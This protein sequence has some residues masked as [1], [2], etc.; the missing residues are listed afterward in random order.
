[1]PVEPSG[2]IV[3]GAPGPSGVRSVPG[4]LPSAFTRR[5]FLVGAAAAALAGCADFRIPGQASTVKSGFAE[6]PGT[7]LYYEMAGTGDE[8]VVL[9][10]AFM[11]DTR[12]WDEQFEAYAQRYRV[13][14]YDARG[15]GRS[16]VPH[17]GEPYSHADD[18]AALLDLLGATGPVHVVGLSMG[19]RFAL[20]FAVVHPARLRSLTVID[21]VVGGWPWSRQWL[22]SYA[23][24]LEAA[25]RGDIPGAKQA[26]LANEIFAPLREQPAV[27]GRMRQMVDDYSGW[28]L[29]NADPERTPQPPTVSQLSK[30]AAPTLVLVGERDV[31]EFQ[32]IAAQVARGVPGARHEKV[33][34]VGH[35]A[36]MEG[37]QRV[38]ELVVGFIAGVSG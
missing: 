9:I 6:I 31:P 32:M 29:V 3:L 38:N 22:V 12:T 13:I 11:L 16:G 28:H 23:P 21:T 27:A 34:G 4:V 37:P 7:R 18:L 5:R 1:M 10:H 36:S 25:R 2:T 30:V 14:R 26:W 24:V 35:L 19:G 15:F 33:A 20:D 8:T 17:A